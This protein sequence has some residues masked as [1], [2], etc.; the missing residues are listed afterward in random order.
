MTNERGEKLQKAVPAT[1]VEV[2]GLNA[3]PAAGDDVEVVKN[4]RE[5]R[6]IAERRQQKQRPVIMTGSAK[7]MTLKPMYRSTF[8]MAT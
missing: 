1:P 5:A 6:Q 3:A 2:L 8:R 7:R 4:D